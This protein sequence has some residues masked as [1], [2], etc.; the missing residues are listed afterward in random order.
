MATTLIKIG[1]S[2]GVRIPKSIIEQAGLENKQLEF[3]ILDD[4]LLIQP[5]K[6]ARQ[7]W[8]QQFEKFAQVDELT[9]TDQDWLESPLIETEEWEW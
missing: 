6:K 3:K 4:G 8:K 5:Q 7:N 9:Q 2:Q 1:N